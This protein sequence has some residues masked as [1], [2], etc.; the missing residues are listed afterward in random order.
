M[1]SLLL[2]SAERQ[3]SHRNVKRLLRNGILDLSKV[4]AGMLTPQAAPFDL[5]EVIALPKTRL[6]EFWAH[7]LSDGQSC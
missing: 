4:E 5:S 1:N 3:I 7:R 6:L 2:E